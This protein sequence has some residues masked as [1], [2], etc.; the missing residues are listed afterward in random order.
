MTGEVRKVVTFSLKGEDVELLATAQQI[1][2]FS[3]W[4]KSHLRKLSIQRLT[5]AEARGY[6]DA[7]RGEGHES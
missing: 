3:G 1:P 5:D 4:V 6:A 7:Q 2:N